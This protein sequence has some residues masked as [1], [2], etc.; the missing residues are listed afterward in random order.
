MR[1]RVGERP[2]LPA[3]AGGVGSSALAVLASVSRFAA[4]TSSSSALLLRGSTDA[5]GEASTSAIAPRPSATGVTVGPCAATTAL[6]VALT[7]AS[8]LDTRR[9]TSI[10]TWISIAAT[11]DVSVA[12]L[13]G[14]RRGPTEVAGQ[15]DGCGTS[16]G[17]ARESTARSAVGEEGVD[18]LATSS[19]DGGAAFDRQSGA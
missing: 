12:G 15:L 5:D 4:R 18:G 9:L 2:P 1:R 6:L 11:L 8:C 7:V 3:G 19:A 14:T 10:P 13:P 17:V 16:A